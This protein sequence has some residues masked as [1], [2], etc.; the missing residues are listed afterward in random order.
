MFLLVCSVM[1]HVPPASTAP[2][3]PAYPH[4]QKLQQLKVNVT[5][6]HRILVFN[7]WRVIE[8]CAMSVEKDID[9]IMLHVLNVLET[10][11]TVLLQ[12]VFLVLLVTTPVTTHV[13]HVQINVYL[14]HQ[15]KVL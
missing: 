12:L 14:V 15:C 9:W 5:Y 3:S 4:I 6:V 13:F 10:V 11:C 7:V 2:A 1:F 8:L